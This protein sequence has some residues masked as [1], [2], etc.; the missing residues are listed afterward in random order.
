[1][2][3]QTRKGRERL[4]ATITVAVLE[5]DRIDRVYSKI[6]PLIAGTGTD[7]QEKS[8]FARELHD[9]FSKQNVQ[10][11]A[12]TPLPMLNEEFYRRLAI[13]IEMT[14][15]IRDIL[16]FIFAVETYSN[17]IKIEKLDLKTRET[18]LEDQ[19]NRG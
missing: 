6:E 8:K 16:K 11:R 10:T 5:K 2:A 4:L 17:P 9:L 19:R 7:L 14:G 3:S 12:V 18:V 15:S 1:M 13:K